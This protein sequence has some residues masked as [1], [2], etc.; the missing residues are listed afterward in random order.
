MILCFDHPP[1]DTTLARVIDL[2][3]HHFCDG[4]L[5]QHVAKAVRE[6]SSTK[7]E[8]DTLPILLALESSNNETLSKRLDCFTW[9][10]IHVNGD[11]S[12]S[13]LMMI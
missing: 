2:S 3:I 12:R 1:L 11:G 6:S 8:D 5:P 13:R 7:E 4:M 9:R 10:Y